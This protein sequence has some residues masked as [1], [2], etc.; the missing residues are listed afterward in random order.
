MQFVDR[1]FD[2]RCTCHIHTCKSCLCREFNYISI[3]AALIARVFRALVSL[4]SRETGFSTS[5][6]LHRESWLHGAGLVARYTL[7]HVC[8]ILTPAGIRF[9]RDTKDYSPWKKRK[10]PSNWLWK[11]VA[12]PCLPFRELKLSSFPLWLHVGVAFGVRRGWGCV[13]FIF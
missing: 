1:R 6:R 11:V 2:E 12:F 3:N 7:E 13:D 9:C 8:V 4:F 10:F 5:L